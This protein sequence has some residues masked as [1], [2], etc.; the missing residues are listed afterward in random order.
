MRTRKRGARRLPWSKPESQLLDRFV[1]NLVAGRYRNAAD[2][3]RVC[4][5]ELRRL[6]EKHPDAQWAAAPRT[7][8]AILGRIA[9]H[10]HA[11]GG[12]WRSELWSAVYDSRLRPFVTGLIQGRS[13]SALEAT[14]LA[15][16]ARVAGHPKGTQP[17]LPFSPRTLQ[18]KILQQAEAQGWRPE[19]AWT[20]RELRVLDS[21]GRAVKRGRYRTAQAAARAYVHDL[22]HL[23]R[24]YPHAKWL[25]ARRTEDGVSLKLV[26]RL[27]RLQ[28]W[29]GPLWPAPEMR[30]LDQFARRV[31]EGRYPNAVPAARDFM[32]ARDLM[33]ERHPEIMW[34]KR[35]R[36]L[37][38]AHR[39]VCQRAHEMG[40]S[41]LVV[42]WGTPELTILDRYV[43]AVVRGQYPSV[44][45]AG[46]VLQQEIAR[47]HELHP[48]ARW[49]RLART[50]SAVLVQLQKRIQELG[51][52]RY[53]GRWTPAER[54]ILD[55][56]A[57]RVGKP[58]YRRLTD[59]GKDC[60]RELDR[61]HRRALR[62]NPMLA[63]IQPRTFAAVTGKLKTRAIALRTW[64]PHAQQ[65]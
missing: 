44:L 11:A 60:A 40:W 49:S 5:D 64:R 17:A 25:R 23:R 38:S 63:P 34:L 6:Y 65:R 47:L 12:R 46:P 9:E 13:R 15:R 28:A 53:G 42:R 58:G 36:S 41:K 21:Y 48:D 45:Q 8:D 30:L 61:R 18:K 35:R 52:P 59:A 19:N 1:R 29:S 4:A 10:A 39:V 31:A 26:R 22:E 57:R 56:Y 33:Q 2:A 51:V 54:K 24:K 3:A 32:R 14:R 43:R 50:R 62:R 7:Y 16:A 37:Q 20:S 27:K 55:R